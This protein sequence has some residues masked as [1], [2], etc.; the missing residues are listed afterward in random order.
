MNIGQNFATFAEK[1]NAQANGL[2]VFGVLGFGL[3]LVF[4]GLICIILICSV[5][6]LICKGFADEDKKPARNES[7]QIPDKG[8]FI[9]AVSAALAE[10][11]GS[12][13][14]KLRILSV[15]KL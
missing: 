2:P 15:K 12:D 7:A 8:E 6:G 1:I 9:A 3:G 10:E 11:L 14:S 5:M 4:V 13:V